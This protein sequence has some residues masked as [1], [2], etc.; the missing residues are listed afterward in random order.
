MTDHAG[1]YHHDRLIVLNKRLQNREQYHTW[2]TMVFPSEQWAPHAQPETAI[3][4]T[5]SNM[6]VDA[7]QS[8]QWALLNQ[9]LHNREQYQH[10]GPRF[11]SQINGCHVLDQRLQN[12]E[13]YQTWLTK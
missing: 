10:G 3:W 2:P 1:C 9:R 8:E 7:F 6:A 4:G 12:R 13:Q 5:I 11:S